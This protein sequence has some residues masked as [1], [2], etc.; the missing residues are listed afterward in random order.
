MNNLFE[1]KRK[2]FWI[3][4]PTLEHYINVF[5]DL[6]TDFYKAAKCFII[7]SWIVHVFSILIDNNIFWINIDLNH[8]EYQKYVCSFQDA[9]QNSY[10]LTW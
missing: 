4:N 5:I 7:I 10:L 1:D 3:W 6:L 8:E 2:F 9:C